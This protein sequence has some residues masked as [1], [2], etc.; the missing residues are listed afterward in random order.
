MSKLIKYWV[1]IL[2]LLGISI[3]YCMPSSMCKKDSNSQ[4]SKS[5]IEFFA[6]Y[7]INSLF[8]LNFVNYEKIVSS[9]S[10]YL[11][12][13][14]WKQYLGYLTESGFLHKMNQD[15]LIITS[16]FKNPAKLLGYKDKLWRIDVPIII[17]L[18]SP[19]SVVRKTQNITLEIAQNDKHDNNCGLKVS[20]IEFAPAPSISFNQP[21]N[22]LYGHNI[23]YK[24]L[25]KDSLFTSKDIRHPG[26]NDQFVITSVNLWLLKQKNFN[27]SKFINPILL[28][29]KGILHNRYS[30]RLAAREDSKKITK[31]TMIMV[32]RNPSSP[33]GIDI[34]IE[35]HLNKKWG[36]AAKNSASSTH[37]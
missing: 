3:G 32:T 7:S 18:Q 23:S 6:N 2:L 21:T 30:W 4:L 36:S 11:S 12:E 10:E 28:F 34:R 8:F 26:V 25:K 5:T 20:K 35:T 24:K 37:L 31:I 33:Y 29:Q 27:L 16:F 22:E 13:D 1:I 15:K 19:T 9:Q 17:V 14:A